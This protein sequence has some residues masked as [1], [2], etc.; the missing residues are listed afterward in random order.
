MNWEALTPSE[1]PADSNTSFDYEIYG[2]HANDSFYNL[3]MAI[4]TEGLF[5]P[6]INQTYDFYFNVSSTIWYRCRLFRANIT[7]W[8]FNLSYYISASTPDDTNNWIIEESH[9]NVQFDTFDSAS[10]GFDYG[11]DDCIFKP[12]DWEKLLKQMMGLSKDNKSG[13]DDQ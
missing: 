5:P 2:I 12:L 10:C 9:M 4:E 6:S 1:N 13:K 7:A 3:Y 8:E 11:A